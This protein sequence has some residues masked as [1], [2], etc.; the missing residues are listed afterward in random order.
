MSPSFQG[1]RAELQ[2]ATN[3]V[4]AARAFGTVATLV[5]TTVCAIE[6]RER[7]PG[8]EALMVEQT[9][10]AISEVSGR[11]IVVD[12]DPAIWRSV[13]LPRIPRSTLNCD[14]GSSRDRFEPREPQAEVDFKLTEFKE[15]LA[16][17][18]ELVRQMFG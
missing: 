2:Q 6:Q 3:V 14:S 1:H 7:F 9:A 17:N 5:Y 16:A 18:Q 13:W 11:E 10:S 8:C 12:H 15:F 4:Q